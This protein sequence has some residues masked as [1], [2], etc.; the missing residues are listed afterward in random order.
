MFVGREEELAALAQAFSSKGMEVIILYGRRRVGKTELIK[1]AFERTSLPWAYYV[2]SASGEE[3]DLRAFQ[4]SLSL[5]FSEEPF[6][7]PSFE[8]T[9]K[10]L[11]KKSE[12]TPFVLAL[13]EFPNL[14]E[15]VK[16]IS[17]T[18]QNLIDDYKRTGT[19][20]LKLILSGSYLK[21]MEKLM[22]V[23]GA[24]YKRE[25]LK[26]RLRPMD[27]FDAG[28]FTP[29]RSS[30]EKAMIYSVFGGLP[31]CLEEAA[32]Y[33]TLKEAIIHSILEEGSGLSDFE[34]FVT[35]QELPRLKGASEVFSS[36]AQ[37]NNT[38]SK[39]QGSTSFKEATPLSRILSAMMEMDLIDK[40]API[41]DKANK[42]KTF[43]VI[44]DGYLLF[45]YTY[46]F[47][48]LSALA[49]MDSEVFYDR[50]IAPSLEK[51]YCAKRFETLVKEYLIRANKKARLDR[52]YEDIGTY[53]YD[54]P[55]AK[56]NGQFDVALRDGEDYLLVECKFTDSPLGESVVHE[57]IE[58]TKNLELGP[59][60]LGFASLSGFNVPPSM[61]KEFYF[62]SL[63]DMY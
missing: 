13:D 53:W 46:I 3:K 61:R 48:H 9:L 18:L 51:T 15:D 11:F 35:G 38:F 55:I 52:I 54:D 62:V 63:D 58:Q 1:E 20:H 49:I 41:N 47:P 56:K 50:Y 37:G 32:K 27:Y 36:I 22:G 21:M 10:A 25:T 40:K 39:L 6:A 26:K 28:K 17:G 5:S 33:P 42:K 24:L 31:Y 30:K 19:A 12:K 16:G 45:Y 59:V 14:V 60:R 23:D 43:Y 34:G 2:C 8:E 7:Y 4:S 57:E 29:K 44:K